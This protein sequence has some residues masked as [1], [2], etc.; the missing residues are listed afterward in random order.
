VLGSLEFQTP[1][2]GNISVLGL[3]VNQTGTLTSIPAQAK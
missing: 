1:S 3:R 2:D